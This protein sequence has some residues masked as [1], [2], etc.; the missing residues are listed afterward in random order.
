MNKYQIVE[1]NNGTFVLQKETRQRRLYGNAKY[2]WEDVHT[3]KTEEKAKY[4]K[5]DLEQEELA[6]EQRTKD[7]LWARSVKRIVE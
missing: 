4:R 3:F 5:A 7:F 6:A 2:V 1:L